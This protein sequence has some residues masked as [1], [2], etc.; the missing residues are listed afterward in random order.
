MRTCAVAASRQMYL[1]FCRTLGDEK[2]AGREGDE[3]GE[4]VRAYRKS[5]LDEE[6]WSP[7]SLLTLRRLSSMK[8]DTTLATRQRLPQLA[9]QRVRR[10]G[11]AVGWTLQS[12]ATILLGL[13]FALLFLVPSAVSDLPFIPGLL[14]LAGFMGVTGTVLVGR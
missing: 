13:S 7:G 11:H 2:P 14:T 8:G 10:S 12:F 1:L 5:V 9:R 4:V 3:R 6:Q